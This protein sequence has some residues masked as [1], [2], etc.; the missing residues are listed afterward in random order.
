MAEATAPLVLIVEDDLAVA[1]LVDT[2][3][4][5]HGYRTLIARDAS[6]A[7]QQLEVACPA[8]LTLDLGLPGISGV[9]LLRLV[10]AQWPATALPVLI[11]TAYPYL[12]PLVRQH[13]Q[14]VVLKPFDPDALLATVVALCKGSTPLDARALGT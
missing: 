4:T 12:D 11:V 1:S 6:T 5:E 9:T 10:R 7:L 13:A 8:A 14:A 2:V 3:L